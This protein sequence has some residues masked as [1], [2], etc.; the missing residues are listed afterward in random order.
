[1]GQEKIQPSVRA[2]V[3]QTVYTQYEGVTQSL[4]TKLILRRRNGLDSNELK[5]IIDLSP[6]FK[7]HIEVDGNHLIFPS[8]DMAFDLFREEDKEKVEFLYNNIPREHYIAKD[9][10]EYSEIFISHCNDFKKK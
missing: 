8:K 5:N 3:S 9:D 6:I 1:M 4:D 10:P 7:L 2:D